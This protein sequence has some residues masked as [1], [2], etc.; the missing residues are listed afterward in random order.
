MLELHMDSGQSEKTINV[1]KLLIPD[2]VSVSP[3][4][5]KE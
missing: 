4:S 2:K 5:A 3:Q 1:R